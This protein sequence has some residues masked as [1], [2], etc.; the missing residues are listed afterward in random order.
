MASLRR[1]L[2]NRYRSTAL[3]HCFAAAV[4][5]S[6]AESLAAWLA[7][8]SAAVT[9]AGR[10]LGG[11][12]DEQPRKKT[13]APNKTQLNSA[14]VRENSKAAEGCRTPRR[15][16]DVAKLLE[17]GSPLP[18]SVFACPVPALKIIGPPCQF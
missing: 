4:Q 10:G 1:S 13:Y 8:R 18:L 2:S 17:C 11:F 9:A 14:G 3:C 7:V 15:W 12:A 16:R 6:P 5:F